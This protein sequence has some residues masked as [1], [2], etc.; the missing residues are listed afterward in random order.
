MTTK[1]KKPDPAKEVDPKAESPAE[2]AQDRERPSEPASSADPAT[3]LEEIA[4]SEPG[5]ELGA[6]ADAADEAEADPELAGVTIPP[7]AMPFEEWY[8]EAFV[9]L[10]Q[11]VNIP[12]RTQ[13]LAK[14]PLAPEGRRAA[15]GLY[16]TC[17]RVPALAFVLRPGPE[18]MRDLAAVAVYAYF[19][20]VGVTAELA[21]RRAA[22]QPGKG[23]A[24]SRNGKTA[25]G[26]GGQHDFAADA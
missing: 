1:H 9:G 8:R 18:W 11:A 26:A 22:S 6:G 16:R 10:H 24:R 14:A 12:L 19:L 2:P 5:E 3:E 21:D 20:G 15:L 13:S 25:E 17:C 7:G 4:V 23:A